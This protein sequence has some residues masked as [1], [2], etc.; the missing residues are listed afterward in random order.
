MTRNLVALID[1]LSHFETIHQPHNPDFLD[2]F[3]KLEEILGV[4]KGML[5]SL[6]LN[7]IGQ[8]RWNNANRNGRLSILIDIVTTELGMLIEF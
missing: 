5:I 4:E 8:S 6:H 2:S 7:S 3:S 1:E